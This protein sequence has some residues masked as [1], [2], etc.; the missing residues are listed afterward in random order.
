MKCTL[1]G[2]PGHLCPQQGK[3]QSSIRLLRA[4]SNCILKIS[5]EGDFSV[6]LGTCPC[7]SPLSGEDFFRMSRL[8]VPLF[9]LAVIA[10]HPFA[11]HC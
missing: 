7:A 6:S 11:V 9:D 3:H 8:E 4:L 5:K 1:E 2:T 10:S